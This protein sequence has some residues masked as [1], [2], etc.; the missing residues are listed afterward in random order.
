MLFEELMLVLLIWSHKG[1]GMQ[2]LETMER[3]E[4]KAIVILICT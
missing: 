2:G 1:E 3:R 4:G